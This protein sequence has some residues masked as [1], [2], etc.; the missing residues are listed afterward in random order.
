M[1]TGEWEIGRMVTGEWEIGRMVAG[2]DGRAGLTSE[3]GGVII[4][5]VQMTQSGGFTAQPNGLLSGLLA[6]GLVLTLA[7]SACSGDPA[8]SARPTL[9]LATTTSA[10]DSGLLDVLVPLFEQQTGYQVKAIAVGTGAALQMARG[11]NADVL[12]VHAPSAEKRLMEEGWGKDRLLV[13]YSDFVIVGPAADPAGVRGAPTA[14]EAFRKIAAARATFVSRGDDSGTYQ[15]ERRIWAS[16]G[17]NPDG[18]PWYI[19][20]GQGMGATLAIASERNAYTLTDRSTYLTNR[21][22]L[23]LEVLAEGDPVLLNVYHVITVNPERWPGV[24]YEGALA[25]ARF[26]VAPATQEI[27]GRFG[28][29]QFGQP[30]FYPEAGKTEAELGV[31]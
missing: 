21:S 17:M 8:R 13:M 22:F 27:I 2:K 1:V 11:G 16:I 20:S 6:A 3:I 12:L 10:Q 14:A 26:L 23:Q 18:Q 4:V 25:F 7:L 29:D 30:L 28:V 5:P 24:N 15:M 19:E 31:P 9:I